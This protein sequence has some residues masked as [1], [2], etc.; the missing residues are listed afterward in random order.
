MD[1]HVLHY[2]PNPRTR[3]RPLVRIL[4]IDGRKPLPDLPHA[5]NVHV[6]RLHPVEERWEEVH[7]VALS[8]HVQHRL[9]QGPSSLPIRL[10]PVSAVVRDSSRDAE[11]GV[12]EPCARQGAFLRTH[13]L[14]VDDL[15]LLE[16][17]HHLGIDP[18]SVGEVLVERADEAA[19]SVLVR[20]ARRGDRRLNQRVPS[21]LRAL[22][23][24]LECLVAGGEVVMRLRPSAV[25]RLSTQV[26][27][28]IHDNQL[29][30]LREDRVLRVARPRAVRLRRSVVSP[31]TLQRH[32]VLPP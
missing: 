2:V 18:S 22:K 31:G 15:V 26:L 3:V 9:H 13:S 8:E 16:H 1:V 28:Y 4:P 17:F 7:A 19:D 14:V 20:V 30:F 24:P 27:M 11:V 29:F 10:L 32:C 6:L 5:L 12:I 23:R 21:A 25:E